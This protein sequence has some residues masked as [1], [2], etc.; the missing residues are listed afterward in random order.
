M[1]EGVIEVIEGVIEVIEEGLFN[2]K[3]RIINIFYA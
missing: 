2:L 1:I 3:S